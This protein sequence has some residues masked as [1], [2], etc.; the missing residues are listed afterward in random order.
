M[1][2]LQ[3]KPTNLLPL[4]WLEIVGLIRIAQFSRLTY[5]Y[6]TLRRRQQAAIQLQKAAVCTP[7]RNHRL[8]SSLLF[9]NIQIYSVGSDKSGGELLLPGTIKSGWVA[10]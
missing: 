5:N 4:S 2:K 8:S 10:D 3:R 9:S 6:R 1:K 7:I